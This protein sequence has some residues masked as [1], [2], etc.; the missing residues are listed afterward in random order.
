M[1]IRDRERQPVRGCRPL[2]ESEVAR[3]EHPNATAEP[4]LPC[5]PLQRSV[6]IIGFVSELLKCPAGS[7]GSSRTLHH[8]LV[9]ALC[10]QAPNRTPLLSSTVWRSHQ[11]DGQSIG[12][13]GEIA[14]G[15]ELHAIGHRNTQVAVNNHIGGLA[16]RKPSKASDNPAT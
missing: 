11:N 2:H 8:R 5:K 6:A 3:S 9:A 15:E 7:K 14:I 16:S 10:K 12:S 1:C 4:I 13:P